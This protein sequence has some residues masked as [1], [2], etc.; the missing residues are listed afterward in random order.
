MWGMGDHSVPLHTFEE[1]I[2]IP[3]I[4]RHTGNIPAGQVFDGRTCNYDFFP[5]V[6]DYL[7]MAE[8]TPNEPELPGKSYS[9]TLL[10]DDIDWDDVIFG[11]SLDQ[12]LL[13]CWDEIARW[14]IKN[15]LTNK[16]G[17]PNYLNY[18]CP[19]ALEAVKPESNTIIR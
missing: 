3:L 6:L 19:D 17:L 1:A 18:I 12:S 5:S 7:G 13:V 15:K 9:R 8:K 16:K 4:F 10:G 11:I 14:G 2:H